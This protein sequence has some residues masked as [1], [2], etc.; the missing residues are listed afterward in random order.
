VVLAAA[1]PT[2]WLICVA[3]SHRWASGLL[4]GRFF[5]PLKGRRH[6]LFND[7]VMPQKTRLQNEFM[8]PRLAQGN[9]VG[10]D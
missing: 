4:F 10:P 9:V 3:V 7:S 5:G 8:D 1:L 2:N 6:V